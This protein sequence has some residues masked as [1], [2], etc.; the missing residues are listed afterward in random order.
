MRAKIYI[1][2]ISMFLTSCKDKNNSLKEDKVQ[3]LPF[4]DLQKDY[5]DFKMKMAETDT[6]RIWL[7]RSICDYEGY[8]KL[9]ITKE[10]DSLKIVS[11]LKDYYNTD[12]EWKKIYE[13]KIF[14]KD[15][16]WNFENFLNKNKDKI[17]RDKSNGRIVLSDGRTELKYSSEG[18]LI[19]SLNFME[20]INQ[21]MEVL[22]PNENYYLVRVLDLTE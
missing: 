2:L 13:R 22:Y 8:E 7:D 12:S 4:F 19:N 5:A 10:K 3:V 21:T 18:G 14:V 15:S 20:E 1:L 16:T 6:L 17:K 11:K 9:V